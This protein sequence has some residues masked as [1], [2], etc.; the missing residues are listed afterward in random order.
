MPTLDQ[1]LDFASPLAQQ[2]AI[3]L[4]ILFAAAMLVASDWRIAVAAYALLKVLAGILL[5]QL[6]PPEWALMQWVV[7]GLVGVMWF[8]SARRVESVRRRQEGIPWW[9]PSWR[10]NPSTLMR[11]ALLLLLILVVYIVRPQIPFPKLPAD[12]ARFATFLAL[13]GLVGLGLGDRPMRWGLSLSLWILAADF[14]VLALQ[15]DAATV[16][17]LASLEILLGFAISYL[18]VVDGARFW[19]HPEEL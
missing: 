12:L 8:L 11:L 18:I 10:L 17:L 5:V 19:P 13:A 16:G 7:G 4:S 14:V 2:S 9:R 3:G 6:M 1:F 15:V